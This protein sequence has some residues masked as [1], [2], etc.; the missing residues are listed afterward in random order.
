M[1]KQIY[2]RNFIHWSSILICHTFQI[3]NFT[4]EYIQLASQN[5][6]NNLYKATYYGK[7]AIYY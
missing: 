2:I 1:M 5:V 4:S 3:W 7:D 6:H